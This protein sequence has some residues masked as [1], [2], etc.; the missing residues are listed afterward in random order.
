M[1]F[2]VFLC[3]VCFVSLSVLFVCIWVLNYCHRVTTQLQLNIYIISYIIYIIIYHIIYHI[4]YIISYIIYHMSYH[5]ISYISYIYIYHMSYHIISYHISYHDQQMSNL[6]LVMVKYNLQTA[7]LLSAY[8]ETSVTLWRHNPGD[9]MSRLHNHGRKK[10]RVWRCWMFVV[11]NRPT[12]HE[13]LTTATPYARLQ[14]YKTVVHKTVRRQ[15]A[16]LLPRICCLIFKVG[17][18]KQQLSTCG[19]QNWHSWQKQR[20]YLIP[21][22]AIWLQNNY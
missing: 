19:L 13:W 1:Y 17:S 3:I 21:V 2:C 9:G 22:H 11:T 7:L 20:K 12:G 4:I 10:P 6:L 16:I 5:I 8:P 15:S 18:N 14:A